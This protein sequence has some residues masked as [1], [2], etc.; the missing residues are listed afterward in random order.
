MAD[1][2][3]LRM[4][5]A[6]ALRVIRELAQDSL[7]VVFLPHARK[8]MKKRRIT[9]IMIYACLKAGSITEGPFLNAN[10]NWQVTMERMLAGEELVAVVAIE[11]GQTLL[12]ITVY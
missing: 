10:G 9:P 6:A 7:N 12:V 2:V 3:P 5:Q 11:R 8:R 1:I 4:S